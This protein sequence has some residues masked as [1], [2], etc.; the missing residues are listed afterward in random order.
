MKQHG[1]RYSHEYS[2]WTNMKTRCNNP[3]G[4]DYKHYG[5]RGI[6]YDPAWEDFRQFFADMGYCPAGLSLERI[7]NEGSYCKNNCRWASWTEQAGN[8]RSPNT[9]TSGIPGVYWSKWKNKWSAR[10]TYKGRRR[11][12]GD[13]ETLDEAAEALEIAR[14][15]AE[16]RYGSSA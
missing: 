14:R 9:N 5:G 2:C 13:F 8:R 7:D 4:T 15:E 16:V 10:L 1:M 6:T 11:Q 3:N 12:V